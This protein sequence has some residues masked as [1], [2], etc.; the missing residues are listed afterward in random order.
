MRMTELKMIK[1]RC[2]AVKNSKTTPE[3]IAAIEAL[4]EG[5]F[6]EREREVVLKALRHK[7]KRVRYA[8][9]KKLVEAANSR[10]PLRLTRENYPLDELRRVANN[11]EHP[12]RK[13]AIMAMDLLHPECESAEFL[14]NLVRCEQHRSPDVAITALKTWRKLIEN[15]QTECG[16]LH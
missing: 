1:A 3:R 16:K 10:V 8:A 13:Q 5:L 15:R 11:E 2:R 12:G 4:T 7:K 14:A 6:S 9:A